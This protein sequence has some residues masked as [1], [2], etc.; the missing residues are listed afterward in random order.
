MAQWDGLADMNDWAMYLAGQ[1]EM[2]PDAP[3]PL[4]PSVKWAVLEAA[5]AI[6]K[7]DQGNAARLAAYVL[8]G[9]GLR[10]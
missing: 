9:W 1:R 8:P 2:P 3:L 5:A 4:H 10:R 7:I 6:V